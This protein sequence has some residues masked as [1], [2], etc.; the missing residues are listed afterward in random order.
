[1]ADDVSGDPVIGREAEIRIAL[2]RH[3]P[4]C[5]RGLRSGG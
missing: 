5:R 1:M 4:A 3:K 2:A